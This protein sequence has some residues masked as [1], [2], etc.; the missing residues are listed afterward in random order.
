MICNKKKLDKIQAMLI[1]ANSNKPTQKNFNRK[2]ISF[3]YC[4]KCK[5]YHT[6]S[7]M[8]NN[9]SKA[10][11]YILRHKPQSIGIEL[12]ENGWCEIS[13]LI[14]KMN[15]HNSELKITSEIS[16]DVL[17]KEVEEN[18]KQRFSISSDGKRIRA[19]QGHSIEVD[20]KLMKCIPSDVL[21]HGS[22]ERNLNSI[23]KME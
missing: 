10:L 11:S 9:F 14:E 3:Y 19:N 15:N 21:Y 16:Y 18:D 1:I 7:K 2:E 8:K 17:L 5:S 23:L 4:N 12:D 22:C 20:L 13:E 6:S